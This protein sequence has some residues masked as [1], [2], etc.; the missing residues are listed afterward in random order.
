MPSAPPVVCLI[1]PGHV[2]STPRLVKAA[3]AL[4]ADGYRVH[5][6]AGRH[7]PPAEALDAE[8]FAAAA[9]SHTLV[10]YRGGGGALRRKV[11]RRLA[12]GLVARPGFGTLGLAARA[13][14]A[15]AF[16]LARAAAAVPAQLYLG[17][18]LAGL[19]AAARAARA[20]GVPFGFDAEDFH[21]EETVAASRN[22]V[23]RAAGR[24][25]Q[26]RLLPRCRLLTTAAPLIGQRY[27]AIYGAR[28]LTLLNVFPLAEAPAAPVEPGPVTADRPAVAYWFSQTVGEGR[29]LEQTVEVLGRMRVPVELH[30]RGFVAP[31]YAARLGARAA[32]AGLRRPVRFLPPGHPAEMA[33]LAAPADLGLSVEESTPLNRDLCLT[34]KIFVYLLAG[35]PQL[36][37]ATTA[38][39]ALAPEL[40]AAALLARLEDAPAAAGRL[41]A[42]FSD[43]RRV[44]AARQAAW[45]LAQER[46]NWDLEQKTLLQAVRPLLPPP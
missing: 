22:P 37:S 12:R 20:R 3:N 38:Q 16:R 46:F 27:E 2:A 24:I 7:Y 15:E 6:V 26:G 45:T 11:W 33:R 9:W 17:H 18:C 23:D 32:A 30:V 14:H 10:D 1:T 21:D 25:L 40:G 36:L 43:P 29:G 34:N 41:D 35:I 42:L 44:Q 8:I 28:A 4:A 31:G 19:P 5:V 13:Q 39:A